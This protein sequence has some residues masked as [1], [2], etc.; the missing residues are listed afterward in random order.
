[1][2]ALLVIIVGAEYR[3]ELGPGD[4]QHRDR[5]QS[6]RES[7]MT[8]INSMPITRE[9]YDAFQRVEV[10]RWDAVIA[11]DV[12]INSPAGWGLR[13]LGTLKDFAS[14][15]TRLAYRIDLIDEHLA[16]G[17]DGDGRGFI[18]FVLHWKHTEDFGGL[19]PTGREG[20]SVETMILTIEAGKVGR[21]DIADNTLDL[22]IYEW[23]RGW[24]VPHNVRPE[25]I[26]EGLDRRVA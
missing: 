5:V 2:C 9:I 8:G 21:I 13:G 15:F 26:L 25:P 18:T 22:A 16:L 11:E 4:R 1:M 6:N 14:Q 7:A 23:E 3:R 10:D 12:L 24:P 20:T 17:S 19:A